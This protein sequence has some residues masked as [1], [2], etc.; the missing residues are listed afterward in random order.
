VKLVVSILRQFL[1]F[2]FTSCLGH[3]FVFTGAYVLLFRGGV[4]CVVIGISPA[5]FFLI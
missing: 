5:F 4:V 2:V 1:K 3:L